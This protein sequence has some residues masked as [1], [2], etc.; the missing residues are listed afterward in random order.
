VDCLDKI[1]QESLAVKDQEHLPVL[2]ASYPGRIPDR[3]RFVL[4]QSPDNPAGPIA[5]IIQ[6]LDRA[7]AS[8]AG[9]PCVTAHCPP[10]MNVIQEAITR[11]GVSLKLLSLVEETA[12]FIHEA[13]PGVKRVGALSTT[14]SFRQQVFAPALEAAG[15]EVV[16]QDTRVQ[17]DL[18]HPAIF[19]P[20]YGIKSGATG[21]SETSRTLVRRAIAHLRDQ[22]AEA[23]ILGCTELP[24]A[25]TEARVEGVLA[26]D[27]TRSLARALIR[28]F[29]PEILRPLPEGVYT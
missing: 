18:V 27:P 23:V 12:R 1:H 2:L 7:G 10:I 28:E 24:L 22:G 19:D 13:A 26:V 17:D 3:G 14:A 25:V 15:F 20:E 11:A 6:F 4:G 8:V 21:V 29:A 16:V 5:E 9:I